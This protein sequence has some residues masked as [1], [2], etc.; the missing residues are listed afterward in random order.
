MICSLFNIMAIYFYGHSLLLFTLN[1]RYI[2]GFGFAAL[3]TLHASLF[4]FQI[5]LNTSSVNCRTIYMNS[6]TEDSVL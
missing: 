6:E 4:N 1:Y 3:Q 5:L 2:P